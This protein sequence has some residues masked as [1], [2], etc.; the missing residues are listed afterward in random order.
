M[1]PYTKTGR[2]PV[3][4]MLEHV[5]ENLTFSGAPPAG[6]QR[7]PGGP[8]WSLRNLDYLS[9]LAGGVTRAQVAR[10]TL[11][12]WENRVFPGRTGQAARDAI[13]QL[14]PDLGDRQVC[15]ATGFSLLDQHGV[16]RAASM[17]QSAMAVLTVMAVMAGLAVSGARLAVESWLSPLPPFANGPTHR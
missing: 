3:V 15:Q 10:S 6:R 8:F 11:A 1:V 7:L 16:F 14:E 17:K 12:W 9:E 13:W 2:T 4:T 5:I